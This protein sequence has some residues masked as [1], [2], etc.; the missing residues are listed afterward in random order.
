MLKNKRLLF[1]LVGVV[2]LVA[3]A[4]TILSLRGSSQNNVNKQSVKLLKK[5]SQ[6]RIPTDPSDKE[7]DDAATPI[8]DYV[9][10][11][12]PTHA[13]KDARYNNHHLV[14]SNPD[15]KVSE[16]AS[17]KALSTDDLPFADSDAVI[18]GR[19]INSSAHLST[20]RGAVY[21][22]YT[23]RVKD[24]HKNAPD[25]QIKKH[26]EIVVDRLGG[27]VRYPGGHIIRYRVVGQG[28]PI[29]DGTYLLFLK[30]NEKGDYR[31]V[32]GYQMQGNK[33]LAMDGSRINFR[34]AGKWSFDKH[35]NKDLGNFKKEFEDSKKKQASS[36]PVEREG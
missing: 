19:V 14:L 1:S 28:S 2:A 15:P 29:I 26:D 33:V 21:S 35:N 16:V 10:G 9:S 25:D 27:R 22:E 36:K 20:D 4:V 34:G 18:E 13:E 24:I 23:I 17:D 8:V 32:T 3:L 30:R 7:L 12:D 6:S 31:V 5:E 11:G